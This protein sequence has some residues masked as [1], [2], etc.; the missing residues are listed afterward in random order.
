MKAYVNL[1]QQYISRRFFEN[2]PN[3]ICS[4]LS[5]KASKGRFREPEK[6]QNHINEGKGK[7]KKKEQG[8]EKKSNGCTLS[9][10]NGYLEDSFWTK[11][12]VGRKRS[13]W[14]YP[15]RYSQTQKVDHPPRSTPPTLYEQILAWVRDVIFYTEPTI[16]CLG[17]KKIRTLTVCRC[18]YKISTPICPAGV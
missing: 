16:Y 10:Y 1:I 7:E 3:K 13:I 6:L 4:P 14:R 11:T 8:E 12:T 2:Q 18:H 15:A 9:F 17:G 5:G